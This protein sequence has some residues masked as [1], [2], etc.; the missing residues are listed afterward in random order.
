MT[1]ISEMM[2]DSKHRGCKRTSPS[3]PDSHIHAAAAVMAQLAVDK[4]KYQDYFLDEFGL[5]EP[6]SDDMTHRL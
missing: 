6:Q 4:E 1:K 3:E 5:E 2:A